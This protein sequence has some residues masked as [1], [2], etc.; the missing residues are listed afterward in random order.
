MKN[1]RNR[2]RTKWFLKLITILCNSVFSELQYGIKGWT[3]K[4]QHINEIKSVEIWCYRKMLKNI[5][6]LREMGK[7]YEVIKSM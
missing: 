7:K 6:E 3:R 1:S 2:N 4:Q 5:K